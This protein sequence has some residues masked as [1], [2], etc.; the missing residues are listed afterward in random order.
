[1]FYHFGN[2]VGTQSRH[3]SFDRKQFGICEAFFIVFGVVVYE[4]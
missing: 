1:M 2:V 3:E 4:L